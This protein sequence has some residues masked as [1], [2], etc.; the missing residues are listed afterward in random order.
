MEIGF[1]NDARVKI[2]RT[3][4]IRLGER[5]DRGTSGNWAGRHWNEVFEKKI[6]A[7]HALGKIV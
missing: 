6:G 5:E 7:R 2:S 4:E 1:F 3:V